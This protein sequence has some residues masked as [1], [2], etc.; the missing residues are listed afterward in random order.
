M[1]PLQTL[2]ASHGL[3]VTTVTIHNLHWSLE[4]MT[5]HQ[6]LRVSQFVSQNFASL[7]SYQQATRSKQYQQ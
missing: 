2:L 7:A 4:E 3:L 6:Q 5:R 1:Y